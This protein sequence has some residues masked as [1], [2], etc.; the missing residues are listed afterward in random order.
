MIRLCFTRTKNSIIS[1]RKASNGTSFGRILS[2]PS[3][4]IT[5]SFEGGRSANIK[6][7]SDAR[8]FVGLVAVDKAPWQYSY[9]SSWNITNHTARAFS[10]SSTGTNGPP[11]P[12]V[13][14]PTDSTTN[15][16]AS[17]E[18]LEDTLANIQSLVPAP[19]LTA[20]EAAAAAAANTTTAVES[21]DTFVRTGWISDYMIDT[22]L[23]ITNHTHCGLASSIVGFTVAFRIL[24]FPLFLKTQRNSSRMA[25]MK[26]EVDL[27]KQRIEKSPKSDTEATLRLNKQLRAL[28]QKY[29]CNPAI[30]LALPLVQMPV[31]MSMFFA[32]QRL[33]ELY[34]QTLSTEGILWF[35][36][37]AI[38]DPY[39]LLPLLTAG[40]FALTIEI[41]K[42]V[43][44]A[45]SA[46]PAQAKMMIM[47]MRG[48]A[49]IMIPFTASFPSVMFVYWL[50]NNL[51]S[52]VSTLLLKQPSIRKAFDI[53]DPPKPPPGSVTA[54]PSSI[55]FF[56]QL[57]QAV[58]QK[59]KQLEQ[60]QQEQ[61]TNTM[62]YNNRKPTEDINSVNE[63]TN[64][65]RMNQQLRLNKIR[66]GSSKQHYKKK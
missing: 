57:Q 47:V 24:V 42:D 29:D 23:F 25:H 36:N 53:W 30:G 38:A 1:I 34:P 3:Y 33:P 56:Q 41:S 17:M 39:Y 59:Q 26:P 64:S 43:M 62:T 44:M 32:L 49:V 20:T 22:I 11:T 31:F 4:S 5:T 46:D 40:S 8:G 16:D 60:L 27:L 63:K 50:P 52:L 66:R 19:D 65:V 37:L 9:S 10:T 48:L 12:A 58:Q 13:D 18:S 55:S 6:N 14:G 15:M 2:S 7:R 61:P 51:V 21:L 45:T 54:Q 28:L 35:P